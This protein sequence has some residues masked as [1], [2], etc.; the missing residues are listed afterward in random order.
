MS[1]LGLGRGGLHGEVKTRKKV[2]G[3]SLEGNTKKK[4]LLTSR[5]RRQVKHARHVSST[6]QKGGASKPRGH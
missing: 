5:D 6:R 3:F 1:R 2:L 4:N